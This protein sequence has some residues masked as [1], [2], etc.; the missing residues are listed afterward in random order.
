MV[1]SCGLEPMGCQWHISEQRASQALAERL[2]GRRKDL[3]ADLW[4][5]ARSLRCDQSYDWR[6]HIGEH[7]EIMRCVLEHPK[8]SSQV[9]RVGRALDAARSNGKDKF[10]IVAYCRS[11]NHTSVAFARLLAEGLQRRGFRVREPLHLSRGS[12]QSQRK[13]VDCRH[14]S[15][16][17]KGKDPLYNAVRD[18]LP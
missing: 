17:C 5:D 8:F 7:L 12:W 18:I 9:V 15:L 2:A 10:C 11:G 13:C 4:V 3:S 16:G 1:A 6:W 14:C